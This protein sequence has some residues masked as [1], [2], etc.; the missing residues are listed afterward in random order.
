MAAGF[1]D[2]EAVGD[3]LVAAR[4]GGPGYLAF[5]HDDE[6]LAAANL[7]GLVKAKQL[8]APHGRCCL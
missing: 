3:E 2:A 1:M 6:G 5:E 4:V 8:S 7:L